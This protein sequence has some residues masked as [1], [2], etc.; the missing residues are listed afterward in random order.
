[1]QL[2][3]DTKVSVEGNGDLPADDFQSCDGERIGSGDS[4]GG[5]KEDQ[6]NVMNAVRKV[7]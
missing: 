3:N 4:D 1:M 2:I 6:P 7:T 5:K